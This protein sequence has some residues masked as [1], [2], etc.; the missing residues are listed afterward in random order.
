M[1]ESSENEKLTTVRGV[2]KETSADERSIWKKFLGFFIPFLGHK[3]ELG[4]RYLAAKVAHEEAEAFKAFAEGLNSLESARKIAREASTIE[5]IK[6]QDVGKS[7]FTEREISE[8][9]AQIAGKL[10]YLKTVKNLQLYAEI[11][12]SDEIEAKSSTDKL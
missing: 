4:E 3:Y 11:K 9:A 5:A 10:A 6:I 8:M 1:L 12:Q 7:S 2:P